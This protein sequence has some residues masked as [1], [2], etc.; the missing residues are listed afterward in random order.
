MRRPISG[1]SASA[2]RPTSRFS[3]PDMVQTAK[4]HGEILRRDRTAV[5]GDRV[6]A[7]PDDHDL[8]EQGAPISTAPMEIFAALRRRVRFEAGGKKLA[9]KPGS[10][11]PSFVREAAK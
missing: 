10:I 2:T 3:G 9:P 8:F 4:V 7:K 1:N 11:I 5:C 6:A